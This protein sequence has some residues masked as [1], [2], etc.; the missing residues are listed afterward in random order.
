MPLPD[1]PHRTGIQASRM[2]PAG[3]VSIIA[4]A[5]VFTVFWGTTTPLV[6][7]ITATTALAAGAFL[8]VLVFRTGGPRARSRAPRLWR[9]RRPAHAHRAPHAQRDGRPSA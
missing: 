5:L 4:V 2:S 6:A 8:I 9:S 1:R 3:P 7:V